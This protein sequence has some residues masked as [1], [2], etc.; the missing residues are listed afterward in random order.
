LDI[1][2]VQFSQMLNKLS[3]KLILATVFSF[4]FSLLHSQNTGT[5]TGKIHG[6]ISNKP[7]VGATVII[8]G[9]NDFNGAVTDINGYFK[10]TSV[11][12]GVHSLQVNY[13][14]YEGKEITDIAVYDTKEAYIKISLTPT[15][16]ELNEV[17]IS[18]YKNPVEST[19][20][21]ATVSARSISIEE[22]KRFAGSLGDPSRMA[23]SYSGVNSRGG[24]NNEIIIRGNSAKYLQWKLEGIE[25]PNPN[26]FGVYGSSGGLLSILNANN[27]GRSN[28]YLGAFPAHT[29]NALAGVFDLSLRNGN[30]TDYKHSIEASLIGLSASSEGPLK[31]T[32]GANY[33]VNYR[34]STLGLMKRL[35]AFYQAPEYQDLTF[36]VNLHFKK[37]GSISI[38]GLAGLGKSLEEEFFRQIDS[39]EF[40]LNNVGDTIYG[41]N[42]IA[43]EN[44]NQYNIGIFGVKHVISIGDKHVLTNHIN[45]SMVYSAPRSSDINRNDFSIFL[46]SE[47][48][49]TNSTFRYQPELTTYINERNS[50]HTGATISFRSFRSKLVEGYPDYTSRTILES[51]DE[52]FLGQ[53]FISYRSTSINKLK[54]I[55]GLHYTFFNLNN[56][57][58]LEPRLGINYKL[59]DKTT[60]AFASGLHSATESPEIYLI[61]DDS[62]GVESRNLRMS[63]SWQTVI[64]FKRK[65]GHK[66]FLTTELHHQYLFDIPI[67]ADSSSLSLI[68]EKATVQHMG[69]ICQITF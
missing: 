58:I 32:K 1:K 24:D 54:I 37:A 40:S 3:F 23:L 30:P 29:G 17:V 21:L 41:Y 56:Q 19:D 5:I 33:I 46:K 42:E 9:N 14:G 13:L 39:T 44:L 67:A 52:S 50:I 12:F 53:S 59:S 20:P 16:Q 57:H 51:T 60:L 69:F 4:C 6:N 7:L 65:L 43:A 45:Y 66:L 36:K 28:F 48:Q 34:Y 47:G 63:R 2:N 31:I 55:A 35:G 49:F 38:Y 62:T 22:S 15:S 10:I 64:S 11:P 26:H 8:V 18:A 68:Y 61:F 25:I 27:L